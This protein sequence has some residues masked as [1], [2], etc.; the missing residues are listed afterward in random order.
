MLNAYAGT[1]HREA[2][3]LGG[4]GD[5]VHRSIGWQSVLVVFNLARRDTRE[6]WGPEV[7]FARTGWQIFTDVRLSS[8]PFVYR[9]NR[10]FL[11][12]SFPFWSLSSLLSRRLS[13]PVPF[14]PL[15]PLCSSPLWK[16]PR[17]RC[18]GPLNAR[19]SQWDIKRKSKPGRRRRLSFFFSLSFFPRQ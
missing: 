11:L 9:C 13:P 6:R 2:E 8:R 10:I 15:P 4:G 14:P 12:E 17:S 18:D 7:I 5:A 19:L 16:A 1:L 3:A